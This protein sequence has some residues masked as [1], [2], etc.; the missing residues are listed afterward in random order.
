MLAPIRR[1]GRGRRGGDTVVIH[2]S[3]T[4][5]ILVKS[6][7]GAEIDEDLSEEDDICNGVHGRDEE[8]E[9]KEESERSANA[10]TP[11]PPR[12]TKAVIWT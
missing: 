6:G 11:V 7:N 10:D 12:F 1:P 4:S 8:D 5:P 2:G 9:K 3:Q